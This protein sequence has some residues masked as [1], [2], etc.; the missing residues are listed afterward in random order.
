V[1]QVIPIF[2]E[3]KRVVIKTRDE[4]IAT[5]ADWCMANNLKIAAETTC[6]HI[7]TTKRPLTAD[8]RRRLMQALEAM[9]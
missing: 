8:Y 6:H 5:D 3:I 9:Q 7:E 2:P 4:T 1:G